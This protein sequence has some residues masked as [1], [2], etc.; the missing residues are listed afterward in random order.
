METVLKIKKELI[1]LA[2]I[3][4]VE[5]LKSNIPYWNEVIEKI[6]QCNNADTDTLLQI[7]QTD[8]GFD[9]LSQIIE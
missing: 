8:F 6:N 4:K 2:K 5:D 9:T 3:N 1:S 7:A